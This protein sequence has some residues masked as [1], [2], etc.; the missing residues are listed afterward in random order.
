[1][2]WSGRAVVRTS[3]VLAALMA[4][5]AG[6]V[7]GLA[8]QEAGVRG[9]GQA[10]SRQI[11]EARI[12][13]AFAERLRVELGL[14]E[15]QFQGVQAS[16]EE[17]QE[18]RRELAQRERA[19]RLRIQAV[20]EAGEREDSE[21]DGLLR[22]MVSLREAELDLFKREMDALADHMTPEQRLRFIVLRD[23][24]NQR[25]Q[26]ARGRGPGPGTGPGPGGA[27]AGSGG[28]DS[29][30]PLGPDGGLMEPPIGD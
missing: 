13:Q 4:A 15:E 3:V 24:L 1:M 23:R 2:I 22:D 19:T 30:Q 11:M 18:E 16:L 26:G 17:F 20:L 5:S 12:R 27:P 28:P 21:A 29:G 14:T 7:S 8:A 25:I 9:R 10:Q 6:V